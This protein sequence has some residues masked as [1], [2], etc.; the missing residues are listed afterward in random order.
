MELTRTELNQKAIIAAA[1]QQKAFYEDMHISP[2]M[3]GVARTLVTALTIN[4]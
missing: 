1:T 3:V 2:L 4:V